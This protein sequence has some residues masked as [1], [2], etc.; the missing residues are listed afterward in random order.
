MERHYDS[1]H[2]KEL[3]I[4]NSYMTVVRVDQ[5]KGLICFLLNLNLSQKRKKGVE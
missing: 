5:H 1:Y 3:L 2:N 4:I